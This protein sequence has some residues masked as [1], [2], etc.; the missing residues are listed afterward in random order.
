MNF[1]TSLLSLYRSRLSVAS[2]ILAF[3]LL[4][5][6]ATCREHPLACSVAAAVVVG[7]V[8]ATLNAH[9]RESAP[10]TLRTTLPVNCQK[11]SCL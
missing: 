4:S 1:R 6:C 5:G 8:A 11:G 10:P 3:C 7:S 2:P 9:E